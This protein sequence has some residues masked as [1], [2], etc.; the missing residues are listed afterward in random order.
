MA[1]APSMAVP[2]ALCIPDVPFTVYDAALKGE[3]IE[4]NQNI[5]RFVTRYKNMIDQFFARRNCWDQIKKVSNDY[6]FIFTP[7]YKHPCVAKAAPPS[8]SYFKLW[9]ILKM[10]EG[11]LLPHK[12]S[13]KSA[14]VCEG[15]GGFVECMMDWTTR[16]LPEV[17]T[18]MH[19]MTLMSKDRVVPCWKL[20]K[21]KMAHSNV[22]LHTGADHTGDVYNIANI[23][24][25]IEAIGGEGTCDLV[26][27][28][29]GFDVKA[30]FN[31]VESILERLLISEVY[32]AIRAC[33]IGGSFVV[34]VFDSFTE[35]TMN[36]LWLVKQLFAEVYIVKPLTSRPANSERFVVAMGFRGCESVQVAKHV[37]ALRTCIETKGGTRITQVD[38]PVDF[39][40]LLTSFNTT[41]AFKQAEQILKTIE[42]IEQIYNKRNKDL[43]N[44]VLSAQYELCKEWCVA[45]D[46]DWVQNTTLSVV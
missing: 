43:L 37:L 30:N 1:I 2:L 12:S 33:K 13:I 23:D 6:E 39:I 16:Y 25:F 29:G 45:H 7:L 19:G 10:F 3:L 35:T 20:G 38:A 15:P 26:T 24:H 28:D 44:S 31:Q 17:F 42:Y 41:Y 22:R 34:K 4:F 9:E 8:R 11:R 14:H 18:E 36:L 27:G 5:G 32:I 40:T 46:L 21:N